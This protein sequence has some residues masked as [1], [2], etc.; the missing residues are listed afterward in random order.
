MTCVGRRA[1]ISGGLGYSPRSGGISSAS[2]ETVFF[3]LDV[4]KR[5]DAG[6]SM[7][8]TIPSVTIGLPVY[9]GELYLADALRSILQQ[10]YTDF[11]LVISD[12]GSTDSTET[13]CRDTAS[14][15]ERVRYHRVEENRGAAWNF[16][17]VAKLATSEFFRFASHDDLLHPRLLERCLETAS[18]EPDA[19]LWYPKAVE[20]DANGDAVR[21]FT[22]SLEL[23]ASEPSR[24]LE[25]FLANY[26]TSNALFGL[27]RTELLQSTRLMDDFA[28]SDVVLLAELALL[29]RFVEI[30]EPLFFRRWQLRSTANRSYEE[31]DGWFNPHSRRSHHFMRTRL[32]REIGRSICRAPIART[33]K[34]RSL[35][36]LIRVWGP[37]HTPTVLRE[38]RNA[39]LPA[40]RLRRES[41]DR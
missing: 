30:D 41:S 5:R 13:I 3:S 40:L 12:N 38:F 36:A 6:S 9:N 34:I 26:A 24:R 18:A 19:V 7:Q 23:I 10:T 4:A 25:S 11:E 2:S 22:D 37:R 39:F 31:I 21:A 20:I 33:A 14:R 15:D 8:R 28:S 17:T 16:S 35:G 29:G 27:I 32:I 1:V